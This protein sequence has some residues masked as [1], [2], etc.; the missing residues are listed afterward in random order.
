MER[1]LLWLPLLG[2][3][4][5][6]A[7]QGSQEYQKL[8]AYKIWAEQFER[9]KYDI[10][11]VLAQK[12]NDITWGKPTT[13]GP[14]QLQTFSLLDVEKI[15]LLVNDKQVEMENPPL[16]GRVIELEFVFSESA[17]SVRVPF[18]EIPLAAE[19]AKFLQGFLGN[20]HSANE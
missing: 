13:K 20:L 12:G 16:K 3:F 11:A 4:F 1:G 5:W 17:K 6:L 18:T 7:W 8:E 19:W 2:A 15:S 9:A 10:Y 14:I